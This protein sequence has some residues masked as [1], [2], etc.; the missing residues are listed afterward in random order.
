METLLL[1]F[2]FASRNFVFPVSVFIILF[3][4]RILETEEIAFVDVM[5]EGTV[6][7]G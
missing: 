5:F 7:L 2:L 4:V 1:L 6:K 3:V